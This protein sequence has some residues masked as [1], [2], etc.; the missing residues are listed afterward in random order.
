MERAGLQLPQ[1]V[2]FFMG[3]LGGTFLVTP[4]LDLAE[5]HVLPKR[6]WGILGFVWVPYGYLF[7]HRGVSHTYVF[8]PLTRLIYM[9]GLVSVIVGAVYGV[10][11]AADY[12]L[13]FSSAWL[14]R[15]CDERWV[16]FLL[17][18]LAGF[19]FSQWLHL[20]ADGVGPFHG[21]RRFWRR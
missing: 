7:A 5:Q 17:A 3:F 11:H 21:F 13:T 12:P 16:L 2:A 15:L 9:L 18:G 6:N 20:F 4:D 10:A 1:V 14:R 19:Y 8:G